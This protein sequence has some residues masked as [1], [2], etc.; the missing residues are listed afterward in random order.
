MCGLKG[1]GG[2]ARMPPVHPNYPF[3][4]PENLVKPITQ[5]VRGSKL[6]KKR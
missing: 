6:L 2:K 4:H 1:V 3:G 5:V